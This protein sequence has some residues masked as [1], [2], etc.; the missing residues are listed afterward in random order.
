MNMTEAERAEHDRL[1]RQNSGAIRR[2]R[3]KAASMA[4]WPRRR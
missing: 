2:A 4:L 3:A 1:F